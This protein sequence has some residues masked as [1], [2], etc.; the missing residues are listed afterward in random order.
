MALSPLDIQN[1]TFQKKK[2]GGFDPDEVDDFLDQVM[3]DYE[4]LT[5][6]NR[7]L[8]KDL[9][10]SNEKLEYFNQL[11]ENLNETL[12]TAKGME[13]Q[14]KA[15]AANEADVIVRTAQQQADKLLQ[16]A[17]TKAERLDA[18]SKAKATDI[19]D[20]AAK[21]AR[22]LATETDDLKAKTRVF[23]QNLALMLESQLQT[24]KSPE[25]DELLKP[26]SSYVEDSHTMIKDFLNK[27]DKEPIDNAEE[28]EV[29]FK[30]DLTVE[31]ARPVASTVEELEKMVESQFPSEKPAEESSSSNEAT[32]GE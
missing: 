30:E 22:K 4:E 26:F 24:V 29:Q 10:H 20:D 15:N 32:Q 25:W 31:L 19:L 2:F 17:Q 16:D 14:I 23:H 3:R 21:S 6:K 8:E 5:Q 18:D 9:K 12:I 27:K 28:K 7:S 11:K 13:R 1:K